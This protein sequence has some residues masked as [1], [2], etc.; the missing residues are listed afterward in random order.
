M[1]TCPTIHKTRFD[2]LAFISIDSG[3][4]RFIDITDGMPRNYGECRCV[5]PQYRTKVELLSDA[6]DYA[7]R[8]GWNN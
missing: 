3:L 6:Q 1:Q 8:A 5:G 2:S 4:W 7:D